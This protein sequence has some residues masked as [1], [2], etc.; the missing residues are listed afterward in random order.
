MSL[1]FFYRIKLDLTLDSGSFLREN[2]FGLKSYQLDDII[3]ITIF[4]KRVVTFVKWKGVK[5][6]LPFPFMYRIYFSSFNFNFKLE[7]DRRACITRNI[8]RKKMWNIWKRTR[9]KN[10]TNSLETLT[11]SILNI[12]KKVNRMNYLHFMNNT[13]NL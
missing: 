4:W 12:L 9:T 1:G 5:N 8:K 2:E 6:L 7:L 13:F 10:I 3:I 11:D